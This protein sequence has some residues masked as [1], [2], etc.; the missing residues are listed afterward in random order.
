MELASFVAGE[1]WSD[2][3]ACTHPLLASL[4]RLVN[5]TTSDAGRARLAPLV[6][7]VIGLTSDDPRLD[8][9][10]ALRS[11]V[12]ALPVAA[13]ERQRALAVAVVVTVQLLDEPGQLPGPLEEE[14]RW[15]LGR[16][17]GAAEWAE[18]FVAMSSTSRT[19]SGATVHRASCAPPSTPSRGRAC[20]TPTPPSTSCCRDTIAD[21]AAWLHRTAAP[22]EPEAS[23]PTRP[24]PR[25]ASPATAVAVGQP[26]GVTGLGSCG[27]PKVAVTV[28]ALPL[29]V[30]RVADR[31]EH[32]AGDG[33]VEID[34]GVAG[35]AERRGCDVDRQ[36]R[37]GAVVALGLHRRRRPQRA[38]RIGV[39][40]VV[41]ERLPVASRRA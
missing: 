35:D 30:V 28:A 8:A 41:V 4:A 33:H 15:A 19:R 16:L 37:G 11:A 12:A 27:G 13:T 18:R 24:P 26:G 20:G 31:V 14:G 6:P 9:R 40:R 36:V 2:H 32:V 5:D 1:R 10:I 25:S 23:A 7:D 3:P 17:P 29:T 34:G 22:T 38:D 39:G 21:C